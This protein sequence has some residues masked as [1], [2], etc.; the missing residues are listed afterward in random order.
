LSVECVDEGRVLRTVRAPAVES[1]R[2]GALVR[3]PTVGLKIATG[4]VLFER[5]QALRPPTNWMDIRAV[6]GTMT[7]FGNDQ[8][9]ELTG[10]TLEGGFG[11]GS[12]TKEGRHDE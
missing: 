4:R 8:L 10:M 1:Q 11:A 5:F 9:P 3:G 6:P 12:K 2:K 7:N